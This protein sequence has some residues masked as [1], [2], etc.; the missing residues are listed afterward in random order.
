M[1]ANGL[2]FLAAAIYAIVFGVTLRAL[3]SGHSGTGA[4][5]ASPAARAAPWATGL[6][7]LAAMGHALLLWH[8]IFSER[9]LNMGL[10]NALSL[11]VWLAA[12]IH[13]VAASRRINILH[14]VLSASAAIA[15]LLPL[16]MPSD[17]VLPYA[18]SLA[19]RLHFLVAIAAYGLFTMAA[20]HALL[21]WF[22][23]RFL[24]EAHTPAV[25]ATLPPLMQ[26]EKLLFTLLW[27]A[28]AFLT[29]TLATGVFFS[30][31]LFAKAFQLNHKTVFAFFSWLILGGLLWG[32]LYF[33]WRGRLAVRWT[34]IGFLMLLLS[35]VGS[36][37]VLEI[38]LQRV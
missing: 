28:F 29:L 12:A 11:I 18:D 9:G 38:I 19:F 31:A 1:P 6:F 23:E 21:M 36:K 2:Y 32:R 24:H 3:L 37:F 4:A 27:M 5:T 14:P 22:A 17:K 10:G 20:L 30:E 13:V 33:G 8:G 26:M 15:L 25:F 16:A 35:Y 7:A 34:L